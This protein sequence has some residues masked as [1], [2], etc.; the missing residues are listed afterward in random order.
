MEI[1]SFE[2]RVAASLLNAFGLK[3]MV[4]GSL[5]EYE[6]RALALA[7]ESAALAEV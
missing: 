2:G 3:N 4:T 7:R 5:A 1:D 6:A